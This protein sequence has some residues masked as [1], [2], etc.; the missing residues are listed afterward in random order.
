M[1]EGGLIGFAFNPSAEPSSE[2]QARALRTGAKLARL[3]LW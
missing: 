1:A 3:T 2:S